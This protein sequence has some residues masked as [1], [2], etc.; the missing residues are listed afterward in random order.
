[1]GGGNLD[2]IGKIINKTPPSENGCSPDM[3]PVGKTFT[4]LNLSIGRSNRLRKSRQLIRYREHI[5]SEP[6]FPNAMKIA[7]IR[8]DIYVP[9]QPK[10]IE[11]QIF[12]TI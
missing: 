5:I 10:E 6:T 1:M 9:N 2:D 3:I 4:S 7:S 8:H 11:Q 12:K